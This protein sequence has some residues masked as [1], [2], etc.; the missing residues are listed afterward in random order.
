VMPFFWSYLTARW[1]PDS[2]AL[3]F[4]DSLGNFGNLW[5]QPLSGGDATKLTDF[6]SEIIHNYAFSRDGQH[7][8]LSRGQTVI[9][10]VLIKDFR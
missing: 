2:Q 9:N 10:V 3:T 4:R 7:L 8:I 5:K 1:T 6:K